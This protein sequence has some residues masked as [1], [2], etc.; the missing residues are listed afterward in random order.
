MTRRYPSDAQARETFTD[1]EWTE[2]VT[3]KMAAEHMVLATLSARNL[4]DGL[5][6]AIIHAFAEISECIDGA[7]LDTDYDG[8]RIRRMVTRSEAEGQALADRKSEM[9]YSEDSPHYIPKS[10]RD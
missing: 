8:L 5:S 2:A 10:E 1:D 4:L 7:I 3:A 6:P 9:W